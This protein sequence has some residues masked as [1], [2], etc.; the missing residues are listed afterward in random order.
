MGT[1]KP[2][3]S[4]PKNQGPSQ[5]AQLQQT[6]KIA[7]AA[8]Q[9][10]VARKIP[11]PFARDAAQRE[12]RF[13]RLQRLGSE[14]VLR[15]PKML[16]GSDPASDI[17]V[18]DRLVSRAHAL[19]IRSR[20]RGLRVVDLGS[21]NG[22]FLNGKRILKSV[23]WPGDQI[24]FG[25]TSFTVKDPLGTIRLY[26][27]TRLKYGAAIL[28]AF[29]LAFAAVLVAGRYLKPEPQPAPSVANGASPATPSGVESSAAEGPAA[30]SSVASSGVA[31]SAPS[32]GASSSSATST[33]WFLVEFGYIGMT[34]PDPNAPPYKG[35]VLAMFRNEDSC[36]TLFA[37][38]GVTGFCIAENDSRW[39]GRRPNWLLVNKGTEAVF[40][41][42]YPAPDDS[43][44]Q[45]DD[46]VDVQQAFSDYNDCLRSA[47]AYFGSYEC[48]SV[49][50]PR[51]KLP[52]VY[53]LLLQPPPLGG[54]S[55]PLTD[56]DLLYTT[57]SKTQCEKRRVD[58]SGIFRDALICVR[59]DDPRGDFK[60]LHPYSTFPY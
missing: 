14:Y 34:A 45:S 12:L 27:L 49:Q 32:P 24:E 5:S 2:P 29:G 57:R 33:K 19:L 44:W 10:P 52:F 50:D 37:R 47:Q 41:A 30:I 26:R 4:N 15:R 42:P 17:V 40:G 60:S 36:E 9:S 7:D 16:V 21:T 22:T 39:E 54:R 28:G 58:T 46:S 6:S 55:A 38:R 20:V 31:S 35:K 25:T 1:P 3:A 13:P 48:I 53:W 8:S 43:P 23:L 56:W 51:W 18:N 11:T 59:S